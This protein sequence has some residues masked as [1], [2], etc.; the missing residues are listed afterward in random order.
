[1]K[2]LGRGEGYIGLGR[3]MAVIAL[4]SRRVPHALRIDAAMPISVLLAKHELRVLTENASLMSS[5]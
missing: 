5:F 3:Q 2:C 4:V 1:M